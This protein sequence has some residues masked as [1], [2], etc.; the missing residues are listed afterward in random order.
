MPLPKSSEM[1]IT[2][3]YHFE[4]YIYEN[5]FKNETDRILI[6]KNHNLIPFCSKKKRF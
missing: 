5:W 6:S 1:N 4:Y 2:G 3:M